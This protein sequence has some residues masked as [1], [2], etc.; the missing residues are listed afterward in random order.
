VKIKRKK[1]KNRLLGK[2]SDMIEIS[3]W[4]KNYT[5]DPPPDPKTSKKGGPWKEAKDSREKDIIA[6]GKRDYICSK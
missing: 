2:E 3:L 6:S 5:V 4:T 1:G